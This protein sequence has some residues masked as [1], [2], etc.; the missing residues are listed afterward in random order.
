MHFPVQTLSIL[1]LSSAFSAS[2]SFFLILPF[3]LCGAFLITTL[4]SFHPLFHPFS[5][6][7]I[8]FLLQETPAPPVFH[9]LLP[10][11][12][13]T[14]FP[15]CFSLHQSA[16]FNF[17]PKMFFPCYSSKVLICYPTYVLLCTF[18]FTW[19]SS[20]HSLQPPKFP[21]EDKISKL[22]KSNFFKVVLILHYEKKHKLREFIGKCF[23][24]RNIIT[25][26]QDCV[27]ASHILCLPPVFVWILEG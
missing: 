18:T 23:S 11:P 16:V 20:S 3:Y 27:F 22:S 13:S 5:T 7:V 8:S 25:S 19:L 10:I 21:V 6:S 2:L 12:L 24:F 4:S 15:Q 14:D 26:Q 9:N 1:I 17:V